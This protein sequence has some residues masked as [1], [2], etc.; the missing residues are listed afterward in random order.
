MSPL[1]RAMPGHLLTHSPF[2]RVALPPCF[3]SCLSASGS[4]VCLPLSVS[5]STLASHAAAFP[6]EEPTPAVCF[7]PPCLPEGLFCQAK[8]K[9]N[10]LGL[11]VLRAPCD[12]LFHQWPG[13]LQLMRCSIHLM[14][15]K[16]KNCSAGFQSGSHPHLPR[17]LEARIGISW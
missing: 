12:S 6:P 9:S 5:L 14:L 2:S 17:H 7:D 16:M 3:S 8:Q 11:F 13:H 4:H 1:I 15:R 10:P